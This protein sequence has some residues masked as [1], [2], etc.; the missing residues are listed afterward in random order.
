MF[1]YYLNEQNLDVRGTQKVHLA[2]DVCDGGCGGGFGVT[3]TCVFHPSTGHA[4][5][6]FGGTTS[7]ILPGLVTTHGPLQTQS[8]KLCT[9]SKNCNH[10]LDGQSARN[11]TKKSL[12]SCRTQA[13]PQRA[14]SSSMPHPRREKITRNSPLSS[15]KQIPSLIMW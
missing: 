3:L 6:K 2:V 4:R 1:R 13:S 9:P 12:T 7:G 8:K 15:T 11:A 10:R 14:S 5:T